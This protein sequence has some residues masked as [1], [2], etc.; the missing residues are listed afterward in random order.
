MNLVSNSRT[1]RLRIL[2]LGYIVRGPMGGMTWHHLQYFLGLIQMGHD[3]YFLEDSG[4]TEYS[5]YDPVRNVTDQNPAYGL[6][7]A[8]DVFKKMGLEKRWGYYDHHQNQWH[9]PLAENPMKII[10]GADLLLNLSCSNALR[11]WLFDI[12]VRV[13]IDT[14]P[15]FTQI[16]NLTDINRLNFSKQHTAFFTFG[17]NFRQEE[18]DIPDDGILWKSTRQPVV[19]NA[20]PITPG[21]E[22]GRY[23]TVMKWESYAGR[24]YNGRHYG[25]KAESFE[26]YW[27]LPNKTEQPVEI[28]V[29]DRAAPKQR[30]AENGWHISY[31]QKISGDP[32]K[33]QEYIQKSKAEFSIAKHGYVAARTGWFSERSAGYLASGRPVVL[34]DTGFSKWLQIGKGVIAFHNE[35][36]AIEGIKAINKDYK[37]HC[38]AARTIVEEYFNS[39]DVLNNLIEKS[40]SDTSEGTIRLLDLFAVNITE[41]ARSA[42]YEVEQTGNKIP[43]LPGK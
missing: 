14:D 39:T 1:D 28:A 18:C 41:G 23:T 42:I 30:L 31:P 34:Q 17:E 19:L 10:K 37:Q 20:W 35:E 7:Y 12:P 15:V 9:G 16:R 27:G 40:F 8:N 29:S 43:K 13:L 2:V 25:M 21:K 38:V 24:N 26:A 3:V 4:D 33:Y 11:P 36:E 22:D 32:W 5:C 6:Q